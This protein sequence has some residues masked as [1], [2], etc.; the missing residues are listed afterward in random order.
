M[1]IY[2][3][4]ITNKILFIIYIYHILYVYYMSIIYI[5][6][7]CMDIVSLLIMFTVILI[8]YGCFIFH[9]NLAMKFFFITLPYLTIFV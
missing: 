4:C 5:Y 7:Y 8:M 3:K 6:I 9:V 1:E 2:P